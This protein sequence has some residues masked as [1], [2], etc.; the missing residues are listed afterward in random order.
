MEKL[1]QLAEQHPRE[2]QDKYC[3]RIRS[4]GIGW[5]RKRVRRVYLLMNLNHRRR[6]KKR[7]PAR[8]KEPL[9][10]AIGAQPNLVHGLY[11]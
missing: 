10:G 11:E 9:D 3:S 7:L 8:V 1:R 4:E 5:N 2:G 6:M